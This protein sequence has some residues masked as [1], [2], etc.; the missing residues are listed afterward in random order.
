M[1]HI[2]LIFCVLSFVSSYCQKKDV[3]SVEVT[4]ATSVNDSFSVYN[5]AII[6]YSDSII[7][8]LHSPAVFL[9]AG[10]GAQE[11]AATKGNDSKDM[12][13][14]KLA[15]ADTI[16]TNE[17]LLYR[18]SIILPYQALHFQITVPFSP[19]KR[20]LSID[21]FRLFDISYK[22]FEKD[23]L[24]GRWYQ[25]YHLNSQMIVLPK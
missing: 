21:Y 23:M 12:Y 24:L 8:I 17:V 18:A 19:Q 7:C 10:G 16:Y 11:L 4:K 25:K 22:K 20:E 3:L 15:A 6:N 9:G 1:K 2:V 14:L 13:N 5:L